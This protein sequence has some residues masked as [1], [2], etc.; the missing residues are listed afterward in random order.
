LTRQHRFTRC[1][2]C[3]YLHCWYRCF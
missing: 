3:G 2:N 1:C